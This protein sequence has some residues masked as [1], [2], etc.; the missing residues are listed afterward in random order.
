MEKKI[1]GSIDEIIAETVAIW[2]V[3][4]SCSIKKGPHMLKRLCNECITVKGD[5]GNK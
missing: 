4:T 1:C 2:R 5:Y 3:W